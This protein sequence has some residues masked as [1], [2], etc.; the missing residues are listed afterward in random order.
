MDK[1]FFDLQ[2]DK[3]ETVF[4]SFRAPVRVW[5]GCL[6]PNTVQFHLAPAITTPVTRI[7]TL[8]DQVALALGTP[9]ARVTHVRG[10]LTLEVPRSDKRTVSYTALA[11]RME[12]DDL[13]SRAMNVPGTALLGVDSEGVPVLLRLSSP[14]VAHCLV[15]GV[16]GSGKSELARTLI[17]S[18]VSHQPP[19][20]LQLALFDSKGYGLTPFSRLPH[21]LFPIAQE[22]L[23]AIEGLHWLAREVARR[24]HAQNERPRIIVVIDELVDFLQSCNQEFENHLA[25]L[26]QRGRRTGISVVACTAKPLA[27]V[28]GSLTRADFP[29]RIVGRVASAEDARVAAGVEGTSAEKLDGRGDMILVAGGETIRFRA[30]YI[31]PGEMVE[32]MARARTARLPRVA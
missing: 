30:A 29:I 4:A 18:L 25:N 11:R 13:L 26:L 9:S 14:D 7:E 15:T 3:I 8:T 20:D 2:A 23:S 12:Q 24:E 32:M 28:V 16:A 22:T 27:G 5:G 17:V 19:R 10:K 21:L 31:R 6:T 1:R